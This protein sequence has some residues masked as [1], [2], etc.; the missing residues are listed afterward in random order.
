MINRT[1]GITYKSS[2]LKGIVIQLNCD[3]TEKVK[4]I[5]IFQTIGEVH[6]YLAG[7]VDY[8]EAEADDLQCRGYMEF[9]KE[10][11]A[12]YCPVTVLG[13]TASTVVRSGYN[14]VTFRWIDSG[15]PDDNK[16]FPLLGK[17]FTEV[18]FSMSMSV[19]EGLDEYKGIIDEGMLMEAVKKNIKNLTPFMKEMSVSFRKPTDA[20][21]LVQ[22]DPHSYPE[23]ETGNIVYDHWLVGGV[24]VRVAYLSDK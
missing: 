19:F 1:V 7:V 18:V 12:E 6:D 3:Y 4:D 13:A 9:W 23:G 24:P 14:E 20:I 8:I 22:R 10:E 11:Q 2:H 21:S 17:Y 15:V 5:P 16:H